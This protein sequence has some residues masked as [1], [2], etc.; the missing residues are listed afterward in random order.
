MNLNNKKKKR[1]TTLVEVI[2]V[3]AIMTMIIGLV[4]PIFT[5]GYRNLLRISLDGDL[6]SAGSAINK[7]LSEKLI[8]STG[9]LEINDFT[10]YDGGNLENLF[11]NEEVLNVSRIKVETLRVDG[12]ADEYEF[13]LTD[14]Y[15][16]DGIKLYSLCLVSDGNSRVISKNVKNIKVESLESAI[17]LREAESIKITI[18][19]YDK[20]GLAESEYKIETILTFRNK[21]KGGGI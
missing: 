4:Y 19:L 9:I 8:Q 13:K 2:I 5:S 11:I 16:K 1:G 15:E 6:K 10:S 3:M 21:H 12:D 7:Q 17:T 14:E 20:K 18:E